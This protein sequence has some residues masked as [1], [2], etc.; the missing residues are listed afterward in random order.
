MYPSNKNKRLAKW[1]LVSPF[2]LSERCRKFIMKSLCFQA[3]WCLETACL[4]LYQ[5]ARE[6]SIRNQLE[7]TPARE[8]PSQPPHRAVLHNAQEEH[9]TSMTKSKSLG[10]TT[11]F[12]AGHPELLQDA[13]AHLTPA[14]VLKSCKT[15][16]IAWHQMA[17]RLLIPYGA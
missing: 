11:D 15:H 3:P 17:C 10:E 6:A 8:G 1:G 12:Q 9:H 16:R 5:L 2:Q 7:P 13:S 14:G 4:S